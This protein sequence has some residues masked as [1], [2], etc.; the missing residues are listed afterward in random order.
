M[1]VVHAGVH[2]SMQSLHL[3]SVFTCLKV[4]KAF[5]VFRIYYVYFPNK[6]NKIKSF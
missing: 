6:I 2:A 3:A 1:T 4:V 5:S